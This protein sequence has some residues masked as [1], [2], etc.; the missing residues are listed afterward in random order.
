M[1][2]GLVLPTALG[3]L[4]LVWS[5]SGLRRVFLPLIGDDGE[6]WWDAVWLV[7]YPNRKQFH[8]I[9]H[10]EVFARDALSL[11]KDVLEA[12]LVQ[13]LVAYNPTGTMPTALPGM[14]NG[15]LAP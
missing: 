12:T 5:T 13:A 7:R 3:P 9:L 8:N 11:K 10:D 1:D 6:A 4:G 14:G 15:V 2:S